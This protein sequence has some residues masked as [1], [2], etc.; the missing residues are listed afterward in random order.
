MRPRLRPYA[1]TIKERTVS[2]TRITTTG[3]SGVL[4]ASMTH[5]RNLR[6]APTRTNTDHEQDCQC[7]DRHC[8]SD[9]DLFDMETQPLQPASSR[10][11]GLPNPAHE[12]FELIGFFNVHTIPTFHIDDM[13]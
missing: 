10:F 9:C 7:Y 3:Q 5:P 2:P 8:Q 1:T 12:L 11:T 13:A 6:I 4:A